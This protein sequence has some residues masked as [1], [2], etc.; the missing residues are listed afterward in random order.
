MNK[1][2]GLYLIGYEQAIITGEGVFLVFKEFRN[3]CFIK[4]G[5][6]FR[7]INRKYPCLQAS[8]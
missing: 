6:S 5:C 1:I 4:Q 2:Q 8:G 7:Y 3:L